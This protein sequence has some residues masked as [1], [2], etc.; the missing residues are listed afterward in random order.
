MRRLVTSSVIAVLALGAGAAHAQDW[1]SFYFGAH[2]GGSAATGVNE[3]QLVGSRLPA[4]NVDDEIGMAGMLGGVFAGV[5]MMTDNMLLG[6]EGDIGLGVVEG[7]FNDADP[8]SITS[9]IDW[10]AHLRGRVGLAVDEALFFLAGGLAVASNEAFVVDVGSVTD[11]DT[12]THIGWTIGAGVEFAVSENVVARAEYLYDD[13]GSADYT[14]FGG[15]W[16]QSL[17]A[18]TFRVGIAYRP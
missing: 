18:H 15:P 8:E 17:S 14:L 4:F 7:T 16:S 9:T 2:A 3:A 5:N 6:L 13:Y 11:S 12:A 1:S 10:N